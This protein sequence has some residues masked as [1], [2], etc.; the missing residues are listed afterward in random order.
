MAESNEI[1]DA[2][3]EEQI[4]EEIPDNVAHGEFIGNCKWFNKKLGY[5]FI[6][7][8]TGDKRGNNI[9][10]HHTGIKPLNSNFKTLKKGEYVHFNIITGKNGLQAVEV[11]GVCGG[12]LMCDNIDVRRRR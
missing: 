1:I 2:H 5:G 10:V 11:T 7:V 4:L 6:T 9:F 3:V 12:P 8:Y